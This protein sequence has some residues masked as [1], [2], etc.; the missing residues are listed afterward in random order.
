MGKALPKQY[1]LNLVK[2]HTKKFIGEPMQK[3]NNS[4]T[5]QK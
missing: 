4:V 3:G 1:V 2:S 5:D